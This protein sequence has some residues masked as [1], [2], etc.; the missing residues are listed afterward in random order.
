MKFN[1]IKLIT[2][3]KDLE[4]KTIA[5]TFSELYQTPKGFIFTDGTIAVI[6]T[7]IDYDGDIELYLALDIDHWEAHRYGFISEEERD[8]IKNNIDKNYE[9]KRLDEE[10]KEYERLKEKFEGE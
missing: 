1:D 5:S 3:I 10:R 4:G 9:Q 2:N 7:S 6:E 8:M